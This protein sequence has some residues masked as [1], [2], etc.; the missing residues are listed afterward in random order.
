LGDCQVQIPGDSVYIDT[1]YTRQN[2]VDKFLS[3]EFQDIQAGMGD[4][5]Q[6]CAI[7]GPTLTESH[8][9]MSS[10]TENFDIPQVAYNSINHRLSRSDLFPRFSRVIPE[11]TDWGTTLANAINRD[12]W[13]R[14]FLAIVYEPDYGDQFE[15]PLEG[16]EDTLG[17]FFTITE[18]ISEGSDAS[19]RRALEE[20]KAEGY[21]TIMYIGDRFELLDDIARI[22]DELGLLGEGY[23]WILNGDVVPPKMLATVNNRVGSSLDKFLDGAAVFTNYDPFVYNPTDDAFLNAWKSQDPLLTEILN[24]LSP[25][26]SDAAASD[27]HYFASSSYFQTETPTEYASFMYDAVMAVGIS[28]CMYNRSS[29]SGHF[30]RI[31][32]VDFTGASGHVRFKIDE[33]RVHQNTRDMRDVEFGLHNIR[34]LETDSNGLRGYESVL[35]ALWSNDNEYVNDTGHSEDGA[36]KVIDGAE[37]QFYG[38][39][40]LEPGP[41]RTVAEA[42]YIPMGT[43]TVGFVLVALS[44]FLSLFSAGWVFL[45]RQEKLVLASQPPFLYL[46]CLGSIFVAISLIFVSFDEDKGWSKSQLD[47]GCSVFPWFFTC[48]YLTIYASL[49]CK[50][51]RLSQL[52][53]FQRRVVTI[54]QALTPF[55]VIMVSTF[56]IL[57]TWQI[58]D[59]LHW[60]RDIVSYDPLESYGECQISDGSSIHAYLFPLGFLIV[61]LVISTA[62]YA[63]K[64]KDVQTDLSESRWIFFGIFTHLQTWAVGIPI[65]IIT[66][67]TSREAG[68]MMMAALTFVFS[69]TM[70]GFVI[71]PKI[72]VWFQDK[73]L[74]GADKK[75]IRIST[76]PADNF[77]VSGL[78]RTISA[79]SQPLTRSNSAE[80]SKELGVLRKKALDYDQREESKLS[81]AESF[82]QEYP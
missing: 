29:G 17:N 33:D 11:A 42:N 1:M 64:L 80:S 23:F 74:G 48:G 65:V 27:A 78:N 73:Y 19:V 40:I 54:Y 68:Y 43:Q 3:R 21:R 59:P 22:A 79:Q 37:F 32:H 16:A 18:E 30:D 82:R 61:V 66:D 36:W 7:I 63:W 60:N 5:T 69:T 38:Q 12:V 56:I 41:T 25:V 10:I 8:E 50:L 81:E 26:N 24:S 58:K 47:A 49:T 28:G 15:S 67:G 75:T 6:V 34:P 20:V 2:V 4:R 70:V 71:W 14:E 53:Q 51:W 55:G 9:G 44:C 62:S 46:L 39:S 76:Q 13:R 72:F 52:M 77:R 45:H 35:Y 57:L 31:L